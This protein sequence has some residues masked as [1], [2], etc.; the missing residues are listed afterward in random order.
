MSSEET[1]IR[2]LTD[3]GRLYQLEAL[4]ILL[5]E[6]EQEEQLSVAVEA[7]QA[8]FEKFMLL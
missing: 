7:I 3:K 1:R 4:S 6:G 8:N 5:E 2:K